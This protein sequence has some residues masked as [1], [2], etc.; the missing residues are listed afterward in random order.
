M[1]L[2]PMYDPMQLEQ[3]IGIRIQESINAANIGSQQ[4]VN[5]FKD[6]ASNYI[7]E[8]QQK[9]TQCEGYIQRLMDVAAKADENMKQR[10]EDIQKIGAVPKRTT[11]RRKSSIRAC[12]ACTLRLSH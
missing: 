11:T 7:T 1:A 12:I 3:F 6:Q 4:V 2:P 5:Q 8:C 9:A 10:S